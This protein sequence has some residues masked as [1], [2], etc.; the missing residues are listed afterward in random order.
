[1]GY[2]WRWWSRASRSHMNY[3][4]HIKKQHTS[5]LL[6]RRHSRTTKLH[7]GFRAIIMEVT[8]DFLVNSTHCSTMRESEEKCCSGPG[9]GSSCGVQN[10]NT[11]SHSM[12]GSNQRPSVQEGKGHHRDRAFV[13]P[14]HSGIFQSRVSLNGPD[15]MAYEARSVTGRLFQPLAPGP[16]LG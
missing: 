15:A 6:R 7:E 8:A 2:V 10:T 14:N 5:L 11:P 4:Q 1:M 9:V 3:H 13:A 16:A 12:S